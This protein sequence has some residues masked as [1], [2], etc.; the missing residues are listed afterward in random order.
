M[1]YTNLNSELQIRKYITEDGAF[2]YLC[3]AQLRG[4]GLLFGMDNR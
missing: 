2:I 1:I 3:E 4:E